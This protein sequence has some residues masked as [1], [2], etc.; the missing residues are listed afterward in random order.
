MNKILRAPTNLALFTNN[1]MPN[2]T[3]TT[4]IVSSIL[5]C[6]VVVGSGSSLSEGQAQAWPF[7]KVRKKPEL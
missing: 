3:K 4:L 6:G 7:S 2:L 5:Q 1:P